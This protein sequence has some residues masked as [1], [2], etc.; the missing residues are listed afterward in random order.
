MHGKVWQGFE[1]K[2]LDFFYFVLVCPWERKIIISV[3]FILL[4]FHRD[5]TSPEESM[6]K[7]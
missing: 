4:Y 2:S 7:S 3:L 5:I 1:K 6:K